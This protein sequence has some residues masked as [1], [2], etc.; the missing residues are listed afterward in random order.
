LLTPNGDLNAA[1]AGFQGR[2]AYLQEAVRG[3]GGGLSNI[4]L[5]TQGRREQVPEPMTLGLL[6]LG[7]LGAGVARRRKA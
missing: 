6:G 4:K 2:W 1:L 3:A 7:L 5:Y